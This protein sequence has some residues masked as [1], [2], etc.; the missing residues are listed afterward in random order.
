MRA[1]LLSLSILLASATATTEV[2]DTTEE[3]PLEEPQ[4]FVDHV[5]RYEDHVSFFEPKKPVAVSSKPSSSAY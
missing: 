1:A 2:T 4:P 3:I 5:S